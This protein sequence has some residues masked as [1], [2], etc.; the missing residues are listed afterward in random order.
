M[1]A[2][3]DMVLDERS[4]P[5]VVI[6]FTGKLVERVEALQV[7]LLGMGCCAWWRLAVTPCTMAILRHRARTSRIRGSLPALDATPPL[8]ACT[9]AGPG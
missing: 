2:Q 7:G 3:H 6:A 4:N 5:E 9:P 1:Q 8:V